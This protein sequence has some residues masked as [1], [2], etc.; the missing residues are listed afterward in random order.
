MKRD[1]AFRR[2]VVARLKRTI[3]SHD[4]TVTGVEREL[5]HGRG[6]LAD[7]LRGDKRLSLETILEVLDLLE[8]DPHRFFAQEAP[9]TAG[10][11]PAGTEI[12]ED[13]GKPP[14]LAHPLECP[15]SS[16]SRRLELLIAALEE[17][18]VLDART[19]SILRE[20]RSR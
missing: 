15:C 11:Y 9:E 12:A 2:V 20:E 5:G 6:Y 3:E 16:L 4:K 17:R 19:V 7:A 18:E 14:G 13:R 8:T 10:W 1:E